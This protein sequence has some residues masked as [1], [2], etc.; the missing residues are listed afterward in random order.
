[1]KEKSPNSEAKVV[2]LFFMANALN[3]QLNSA[4]PSFPIKLASDVYQKLRDLIKDIDPPSL[5]LL[6]VLNSETAELSDLIF[7]FRMIYSVALPLVLKYH[8]SFENVMEI[9]TR[10][11][12]ATQNDF[13]SSHHELLFALGLNE[14]WA[15]SALFLSMLDISIN[16]KLIE[17]GEK[18]N[19]VR[20][21][22]FTKRVE[23]ITDIGKTKGV[24]L[25]SLLI[26]SFYKVRNR[27][28]HEGKKPNAE[29]LKYISEFVTAFYSNLA[30]I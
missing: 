23:K 27:V 21:M 14:E 5:S 24:E 16:K 7:A 1:M 18:E 25:Q 4:H 30:H 11:I 6:P 8:E 15:S 2:Q 29:E 9:A 28:L 22:S 10:F 20:E 17:V 13:L 19:V 12:G 3:E 26:D